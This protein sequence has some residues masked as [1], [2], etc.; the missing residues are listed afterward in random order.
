MGFV[1]E[2]KSNKILEL[3]GLYVLGN[4]II[5]GADDVRHIL[6]RHGKDG[7]SDHSMAATE[8]IAHLSYVLSNYD[9]I[10]WD[11]GVS[12]HYKTKDGKKAPQITIK[13]RIDGTY[14]IIE[15][16]SDS[17]KNRNIVSTCYLKKAND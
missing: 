6:K 13:K 4:R 10:E 2:K 1:N 14:Y 7:K 5:L 8:D 12:S 3:T 9:C 15:V 17:S 16:V 11:G